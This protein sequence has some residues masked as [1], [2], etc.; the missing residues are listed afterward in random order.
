MKKTFLFAIITTVIVVSFASAGTLWREKLTASDGA[1]YELFGNSVA[2]SGD[3]CI[4]GA[5]EGD[6]D[7]EDSGSA[8]IFRFNGTQWIEEAK[9]LAFDGEYNDGFGDSVSVSNGVCLVGAQG[10]DD[11]GSCSGSA[12]VYR[13]NGTGWEY[14]A[15]IVAPDAKTFDFFG[16]SVSIDGNT[17]II[18]KFGFGSNSAYIFRFDDTT[19]AWIFETKL[20]ASDGA[21]GDNFGVSFCINNNVSI[22]GSPL[23]DDNGTASGSAYIFRFNGTQWIQEAKL[24]AS[25]GTAE[26]FFGW[27]VSIDDNVCVIGAGAYGTPGKAYVFQLE[28]S[29]WVQTDKLTAS[30][31]ADGD[32]F[33]CSV[34]VDEDVIVVG[35]FAGEI[36]GS[37]Q[38]QHIFSNTNSKNG[39][40]L[41]RLSR[42]TE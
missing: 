12:Y 36:M 13:F 5:R 2:I 32:N 40:R 16:H 8:Y 17:C 15:K 27:S 19:K 29:N 35:A 25:D 11:R 39:S 7:E 23:D 1:G 38:A 30:D 14:E 24:T 31:G 18:G 41:R 20:I 33:G 3:V 10:D 34:S 28:D 21:A 9:L 4:V 42:L 22:V 26:D 6:G 37:K